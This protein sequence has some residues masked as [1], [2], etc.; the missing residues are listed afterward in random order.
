MS[1]HLSRGYSV[2]SSDQERRLYFCI[3]LGRRSAP[4]AIWR[5]AFYRRLLPVANRWNE[6]F[7]V[8]YRYPAELDDFL[9]HNRKAGQIQAQS[10]LSRL[11]A[12]D[13]LAL[14]RRIDGE[15]V[16]PLQIVVL[17]SEPGKHFQGGEFV[18]TERR[19]RMQ[20]RSVVLP[21]KLGDAAIISTVDRPFKGRKDYYR[22]S[23]KHAISRVRNGERL[24]LELSLHDSR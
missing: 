16:F 4:L 19:P 23:L 7:G 10:Y 24:G 6:I 3:W 12:E 9:E 21:L 17:L 1:F 2:S 22:V 14:H 13:Y 8:D 18:R 20:S 5:T 11:G 15:H